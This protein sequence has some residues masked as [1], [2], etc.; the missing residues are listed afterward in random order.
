CSKT[1]EIDSLMTAFNS[2][3]STWLIIVKVFG[4]Y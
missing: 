2:F 1:S 3:F 4:K